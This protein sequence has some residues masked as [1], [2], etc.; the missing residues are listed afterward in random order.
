MWVHYA[1]GMDHLSGTTTL[2]L[3]VSGKA[4]ALRISRDVQFR[5]KSNAWNYL[6]FSFGGSIFS[7]TVYHQQV[8]GHRDAR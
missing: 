1:Y 4:M 8:I 6:A 3:I 7:I 2:R 5:L